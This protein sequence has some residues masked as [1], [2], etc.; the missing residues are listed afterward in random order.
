ME[1]LQLTYFCHAAQTQNFSHTAKQF[2]VPPSNISQS[3]KRLEEELGT[4]LFTRR[5]NRVTLNSRGEAFYREVGTALEL[6]RRAEKKARGVG[7]E[8]VLRL[9]VHISRRVVMQTVAEFRGSYPNVDIVTEHGDRNQ[10]GDFDFVISDEKFG[11]AEYV[12]VCA[13]PEKIVLAAKRGTF[14]T[15][16]RLG[17]ED[18]ADKPFITTGENHSMHDITCHI[19]GELGFNPRIALQGEDPEYIRQCVNLG[20]GVAF[21]PTV[22][23]R[24]QFAAEVEL[25]SVGEQSRDICIYKRKNPCTSE[26]AQAFCRMLIENYERETVER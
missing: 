16:V 26:Y 3:V 11:N 23:W 17:A 1:L 18:L 4:E 2:N 15:G 21:A 12:K 10:S 7:E 5:A 19:C 8:Q 13:F 9:G 22:S 20:L 25:H 24:G 14:P 6:I